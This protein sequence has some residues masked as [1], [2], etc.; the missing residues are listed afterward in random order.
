MLSLLSN[1]FAYFVNRRNQ[2]FDDCHLPIYKAKVPIIS[3]GNLS[4]GGTGKTP[5]TMYIAKMLI[6]NN[7]KPAIIGRGYKSKKKNGVIV[8]SG[9]EILVDSDSA[10][11]EMLM[12]ANNLHIPIVTHSKKYLAAQI[13]EKNFNIDCIIVDDGF[14]HRFLHRN[15]DIILIDNET[16]HKPYLLPKGRLREP[17]SSIRR[18]DII[19]INENVKD[20]SSINCF[21]KDKLVLRNQDRIVGYFSVE[22]DA[23]ININNNENYI[24]FSGI[25]KN[26]NFYNSLIEFG[27]KVNK[28]FCYS[29]HQN[30]LESE[31]DEIINYS[32]INKINTVISTEKDSVKM[33]RFLNKFAKN[34]I[35]LIYLKLSTIV[36]KNSDLLLSKLLNTIRKT[37]E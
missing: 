35:E 1:I 32:I 29:D 36:N 33:S 30:Y 23:L 14:Q 4:T 17:F 37:N 7:I 3:V 15:L 13:V 8:C 2:K 27:I 12:L 21:L 22:T 11:D 19:C 10:G 18:A 34:N 26:Q 31:I 9:N 24:A 25:A 28:H 16:I 20:Y 6:E 5:F